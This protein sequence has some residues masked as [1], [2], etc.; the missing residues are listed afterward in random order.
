[1]HMC[2]WTE[3]LSSQ[4]QHRQTQ[5]SSASWFLQGRLTAV[6]KLVWLI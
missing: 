5:L 1:M 4:D 3:S 2:L 6:H